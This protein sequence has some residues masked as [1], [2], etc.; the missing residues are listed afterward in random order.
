MG[1]WVIKKQK[2]MK[3]KPFAQKK[4]YDVDVEEKKMD[5]EITKFEKKVN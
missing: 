2:T 1:I 4:E 3:E 5:D